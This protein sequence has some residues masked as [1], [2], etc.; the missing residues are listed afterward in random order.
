[1]SHE[2]NW[3]RP[4]ELSFTTEFKKLFVVNLEFTLKLFPDDIHEYNC[5]DALDPID[6]LRPLGKETWSFPVVGSQYT[7]CT[8]FLENTE[9]LYADTI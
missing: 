9:I 8:Q 7:V 6:I 5:E 3:L 1:M 2:S 4:V